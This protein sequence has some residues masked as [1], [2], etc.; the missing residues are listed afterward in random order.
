MHDTLVFS[1]LLALSPRSCL[2]YESCLTVQPQ[3]QSLLGSSSGTPIVA[4]RSRKSEDRHSGDAKTRPTSR[5]SGSS[6]YSPIDGP[7]TKHGARVFPTMPTKGRPGPQ[8]RD[9]RV[10]R[11]R[12]SLAELAEFLRSTAPSAPPKV[13]PIITSFRVVGGASGPPG[14]DSLSKLPT[15]PT[16]PSTTQTALSATATTTTT[17]AATRRPK[18]QAREAIVDTKDNSDLIDFIRRGP[19]S[20]SGNPRIPK[21]IAPFRS[22]MDSELMS[23]ALGGKAVDANLRSLD[24]RSSNASTN[25]SSLPPSVHSS[26]NSHSALLKKQ[27]GS[28]YDAMNSTEG[29]FPKRKTRRVRDPYAIDFSDEEDEDIDSLAQLPPKRPHTSKEESLIDFL[30]SYTPPPA[31]PPQ[32]F[33]ISQTQALLQAKQGLQE[34]QQQ[35]VPSK[36]KK[37][38]SAPS[39]MARLTR[40]DSSAAMRPSSP[41]SGFSAGGTPNSPPQLPSVSRALSSRA[42]AGSGTGSAKFIPLQVNM[43]DGDPYAPPLTRAGTAGSAGFGSTSTPTS[44]DNNSNVPKTSGSIT[45]TAQSQRRVP[46]KKFEP[47]EPIAVPTRATADLAQFLRSS[48]PPPPGVLPPSLPQGGSGVGEK[49]DGEKKRGGMFARRKKSTLAL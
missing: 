15:D 33:N 14:T 13:T 19:P 7:S 8:A 42:S 11:D 16:Q 34:P 17:S 25:E 26:I 45:S 28:S 47:R 32:P 2:T 31:P 39:L 22:T 43:P 46:M 37:K 1:C 40:R 21:D 12:E 35:Q 30:N 48:E 6:S 49:E 24:P 23:N 29:S 5:A 18:F 27:A 4:V 36:P 38:A 44:S 3:S 41:K 9:A 20:A 10:V